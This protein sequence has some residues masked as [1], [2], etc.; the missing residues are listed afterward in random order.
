M[1]IRACV[2]DPFFLFEEYL[3]IVE[4]F[5]SLNVEYNSVLQSVAKFCL[6]NCHDLKYM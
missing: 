3:C 2:F 4:N 5:N 6:A 1:F